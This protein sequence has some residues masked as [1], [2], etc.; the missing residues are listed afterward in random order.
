MVNLTDGGRETVDVASAFVADMGYTFPVF[1]D[2]QYSAAT[3]YSVSAI[4]ATYLIHARG[5][6]VARGTGALDAATLEQGIAM[7]LTEN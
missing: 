3:A 5:E 6:I 2:T 1:F 7:I 4:P